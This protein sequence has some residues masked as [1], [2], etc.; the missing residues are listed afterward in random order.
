MIFIVTLLGLIPGASASDTPTQEEDF[1]PALVSG[2]LRPEAVEPEEFDINEFIGQIMRGSD[3]HA[4][5]FR[6]LEKLKAHRHDR[7]WLERDYETTSYGRAGYDIMLDLLLKDWDHFYPRW[8]ERD[9]KAD[10][11]VFCHVAHIP[12]KDWDREAKKWV[13]RHDD[14]DLEQWKAMLHFIKYAHPSLEPHENCSC[15]P[16]P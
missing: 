3:H 15:P 5:W 7:W 9:H 13:D 14:P 12:P 11:I 4:Q 8:E 2:G 16:I 6:D 10:A 1:G